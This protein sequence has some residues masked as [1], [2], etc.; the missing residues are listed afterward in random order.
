[1]ARDLNHMHDLIELTMRS[2]HS[3]TL[4]LA[5]LFYVLNDKGTMSKEEFE[6]VIDIAARSAGSD[7]S[8]AALVQEIRGFGRDVGGLLK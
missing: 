2:T 4:I 6:S 8:E 7:F 3:A 5:A 1:M